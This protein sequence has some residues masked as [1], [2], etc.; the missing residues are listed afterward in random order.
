MPAIPG[1][2]LYYTIHL[3]MVLGLVSWITYLSET[4]HKAVLF[5]YG[6]F[7]M[8][9]TILDITTFK[10]PGLGFMEIQ[11]DRFVFFF[12][13]AYVIM[14]MRYNHNR[15]VFRRNWLIP[16]HERM[17]YAYIFFVIIALTYHF[18]T[19]G[20][21]EW[22]LKVIHFLSLGA[23]FVVMKLSTDKGLFRGIGQ[24]MVIGAVI[25][26]IY[27]IIQF[28][29]DPL[30]M[31]YGEMRIAY[32]STVRSNGMFNTE[33]VHSYFVMASLAWTLIMIKQ[34]Y[35]KLILSG[36]FLFGILVTFHRMSWLII[37]VFLAIY[38]LWFFRVRL[39]ILGTVGLGV[40][41]LLMI[42][43]MLYYQDIMNSQM[44]Q[45]RL[46]ERVDSRFGYYNMV[47]DNIGDKPLFGYGNKKNEVYYNAMLQITKSMARATGDEG[48][49]HNGYLSNLFYYGIF[50]PILFAL[51]IFLAMRFFLKLAR[52]NAIY[53]IP[54]LF[55]IVFAIANLTNSFLPQKHI[56]LLF[57][58]I[59]GLFG[60]VLQNKIFPFSDPETLA[61]A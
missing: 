50:A 19:L 15:D 41:T 39:T 16:I 51:M 31:R 24:I 53:T 61:E 46:N 33:Y 38:L 56:A 44:V 8:G 45:E 12:N 21:K 52:I 9:G 48:S 34:N 2:E 35:L 20:F 60:G 29:V 58:I 30:F 5:V 37:I 54:F 4:R 55:A 57:G 18:Q 32:G 59:M 10:I 28:L 36:L 17:I 42:V 26:C 22:I 3:L 27:A 14:L 47:F 6:L 40:I 13:I 43:G 7:L 23:L 11:P 25:S 49:I 1:N